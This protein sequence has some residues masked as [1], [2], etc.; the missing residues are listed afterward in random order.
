MARPWNVL[1]RASLWRAKKPGAL[2]CVVACFVGTREYFVS[3]IGPIVPAVERLWIV[4]PIQVW[5]VCCV[6]V[7]V[8]CNVRA[9]G[10]WIEVTGIN[11]VRSALHGR[12]VGVRSIRVLIHPSSE[13]GWN[14]LLR[15]ARGG[16]TVHC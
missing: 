7:I 3:I 15:C 8:A 10:D 11:S 6:C 1:L 9:I 2:L 4:R 12:N 14:V 13:L 16:R 5:V